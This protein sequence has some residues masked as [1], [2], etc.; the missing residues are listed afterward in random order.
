MESKEKQFKEK[1]VDSASDALDVVNN[2]LNKPNKDNKK[3]SM[4]FNVF[5]QGMKILH[6]NQVRELS[7][8]SFS[9]KLLRWLPDD[10][11]R[12]RYIELTN[13]T[14]KSILQGRPKGK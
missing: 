2:Y 3:A 12:R 10:N 4:A 1:V 7:E 5:K 8:K 9:L 14:A 11:V 13:P 6:L